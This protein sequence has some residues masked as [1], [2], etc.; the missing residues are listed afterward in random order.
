MDSCSGVDRQGPVVPESPSH[1][2]ITILVIVI[3]VYPRDKTR[4]SVR[5]ARLLR[6][7]AERHF[8]ASGWDP[9]PPAAAMAM[10]IPQRPTFTEAIGWRTRSDPPDDAAYKRRRCAKVLS[11]PPLEP[12]F[13]YGSSPHVFRDGSAAWR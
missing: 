13:D 2:F 8:R 10:P 11:N 4:G 9:L 6:A 1:R 7:K 3:G 5:R 12:I